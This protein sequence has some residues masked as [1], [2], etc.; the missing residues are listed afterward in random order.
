MGALMLAKLVMYWRQV[1]AVVL[2][3]A[4]LGGVY[5]KGRS[6]STAAWQ[7]KELA[8]Q[9]ADAKRRVKLQTEV[10]ELAAALEAAR[11]P[12]EAIVRETIREVPRYVKSPAPACADS[13]LNSGG[14]RVL[15]DAA[16][17]RTAPDPAALS[18][19]IPLQAQDAAASIVTDLAGCHGNADQ[20]DGWQAYFRAV[21]AAR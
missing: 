20:V 13:G 16:A 2:V 8:R 4:L 10:D 5:V 17:M 15:Y 1:A 6:D 9:V 11:A 14:F 3:V 7:A 12:R 21:N 18:T 19:A